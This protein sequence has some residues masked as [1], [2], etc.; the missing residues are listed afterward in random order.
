[1][2]VA[3]GLGQPGQPASRMMLQKFIRLTFGTVNDDVLVDEDASFL[4]EDASFC[5]SSVR[6]VAWIL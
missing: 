1:L 6:Q 4:D 5:Q 3:T 2:F